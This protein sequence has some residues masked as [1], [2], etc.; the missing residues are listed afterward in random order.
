M[1]WEFYVFEND[2]VAS[3]DNGGG[4]LETPNPIKNPLSFDKSEFS[5]HEENKRWYENTFGL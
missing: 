4:F 5:K 2:E 3:G 1:E